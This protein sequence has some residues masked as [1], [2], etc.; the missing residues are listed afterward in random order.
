MCDSDICT[1]PKTILTPEQ[2]TCHFYSVSTR[3]KHID[4]Y[5]SEQKKLKQASYNRLDLFENNLNDHAKKIFDLE[6]G[7]DN[8]RTNYRL[9]RG[10]V[11]D[12]FTGITKRLDLELEWDQKMMK[13]GMRELNM[14][15]FGVEVK[16]PESS[17]VDR[18]RG[19]PTQQFDAFTKK[20]DERVAVL[21][22]NV[23]GAVKVV[24]GLTGI[25]REN[26]GDVVVRLQ[27]GVGDELIA[28]A[29]EREKIRVRNAPDDGSRLSQ[30]APG[31]RDVSER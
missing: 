25:V 30:N 15:S 6:A 3:I 2:L 26:F 27:Q 12:A 19:I 28:D 31:A 1:H 23:K 9:L 29:E 11:V 5:I 21:T 22:E 24:Q 14:Q 8:W 7:R 17:L 18:L 13:E 10:S 16:A 20:V 4:S